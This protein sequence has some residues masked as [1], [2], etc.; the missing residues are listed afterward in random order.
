MYSQYCFFLGQ[1]SPH[2]YSEDFS[3]HYDI[4]ILTFLF[5]LPTSYA[6]IYPIISL[7]FLSKVTVSAVINTPFLSSNTPHPCSQTLLFSIK[8]LLLTSPKRLPC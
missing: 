3:M 2:L 4:A 6:Y 7:R 1:K 5:L 8:T